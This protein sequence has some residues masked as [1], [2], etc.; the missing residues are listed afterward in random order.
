[1]EEQSCLLILH[2]ICDICDIR[3]VVFFPMVTIYTPSIIKQAT[4]QKHSLSINSYRRKGYKRTSSHNKHT[5]CHINVTLAGF[6][7]AIQGEW[8]MVNL[9]AST[10]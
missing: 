10:N 8:D 4:Y 1:M 3:K 6:L 2:V 9:I 5:L 7:D